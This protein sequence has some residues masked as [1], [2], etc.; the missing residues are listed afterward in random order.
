MQS[1]T[2]PMIPTLGITDGA[3]NF[4]A[5]TRSACFLSAAV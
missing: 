2:S 4:V 3:V 5:N 1:G